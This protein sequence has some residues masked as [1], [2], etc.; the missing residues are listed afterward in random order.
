[1]ELT[2]LIDTYCQAWSE[3]SPQRRA[4]LI[5]RVWAPAAS[6]TDPTVHAL[7]SSELLAHIAKVLARRPGSRVVRTSQVDEHHGVARFAWRAVDAGGN[8]LPE[9]IDIA[10]ISA[11]GTRIERIIGFFGPLSR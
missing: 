1:M 8:E 11:D 3:A 10:F 6:Y 7:G 5:A 2:A 4:E 9:G